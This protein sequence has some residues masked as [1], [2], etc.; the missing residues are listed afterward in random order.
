MPFKADQDR[1]QHI[2]GVHLLDSVLRRLKAAES[3]LI[4]I[5]S[6][7]VSLRRAAEMPGTGPRI[8]ILFSSTAVCAKPSG[9]SRNSGDDAQVGLR[10]ARAACTSSQ[11]WRGAASVNSAGRRR[12]L[13]PLRTISECRIDAGLPHIGRFEHSERQAGE[14]GQH[15][16]LLP[17]DRGPH[18]WQPALQCY[19]D[20]T[21]RS[22]R[23]A[24]R[25]DRATGG[26]AN[27]RFSCRAAVVEPT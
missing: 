1:R 19:V 14:P 23:S 3:P 6:L 21:K 5:R 7:K 16:L 25:L 4:F 2:P 18:L 9:P 27:D 17:H 11:G 13:Y 8:R 26:D 22:D 10:P 24:L 15:W 12:S 20:P